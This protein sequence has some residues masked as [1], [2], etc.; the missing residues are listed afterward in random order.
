VGDTVRRAT[1]PWSAA[2]HSLL[3]HLEARGFAGAPR[4]RGLD[5]Q[6]REILTFLPGEVGRYPLPAYMWSDSALTGA[7]RLL[8]RYHDATVGFVPPSDAQWQMVYPDPAQHEVLC[9]NDFAP[10]NLTFVDEQ[11]VGI[12]DFDWAGPG[13][14]LWDLAYAA[15]RFVPVSYATDVVAL[16]LA[17]PARQAT[18]LR[19]FCA[20]YGDA[21]P[22]ALLP[23]IEARLEQM[24]ATIRTQAAAGNAAF[25][26]QLEEGHLAHY[27]RE[28]AAF[29]E[30]RPALAAALT[31]G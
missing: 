11:P 15:Y 20:A 21:D 3:R 29:H 9:H 22:L 19:R 18:R 8:R 12:I 30:H 7:A 13:P 28:R 6:G 1:G 17:D 4:F 2:V 16:G 26:R 23:W 31:R 25:Q 14:R 24:C 27:Q 5:A 10:Y